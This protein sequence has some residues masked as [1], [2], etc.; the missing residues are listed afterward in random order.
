MWEDERNKKGGRWILNVQN[1]RFVDPIWMETVRKHLIAI[2]HL[3]L[4]VVQQSLV[5]T[6]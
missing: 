1:R 4:C 2:N 3:C 6:R 5:V